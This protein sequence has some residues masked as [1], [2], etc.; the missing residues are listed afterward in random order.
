MDQ[1]DRVSR[2]LC[3]GRTATG[4]SAAALCGCGVLS[5]PDEFTTNQTGDLTFLETLNGHPLSDS[6]EAA[7]AASSEAPSSRP[8]TPGGV[9]YANFYAFDNADI[10]VGGHT[11]TSDCLGRKLARN[12]A[13]NADNRE[14]TGVPRGFL[15]VD[16]H[17]NFPHHWPT[18]CMT[19]RTLVDHQV[20]ADQIQACAGLTQP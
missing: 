14:I 4:L 6:C 5:M 1:Q 17:P 8:A 3:A 12:L 19:L 10:L 20:P 15:N 7:P 13:P 2:Q 18:I 9:L 11:Q 16:T